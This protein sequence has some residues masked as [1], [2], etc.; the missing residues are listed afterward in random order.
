MSFLRNRKQK[1][2]LDGQDFLW[3]DVNAQIPQ[4]Y[5]LGP[6]FFLIY[7]NDLTNGLPS[8]AELFADATLLFSVVHNL[9]IQTD[10]LNNDFVK[11][12]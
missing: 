12:D 6:V 9:S 2:A 1:V 10:E 8:N 7:I 5:I 11:I 4:G 3:A